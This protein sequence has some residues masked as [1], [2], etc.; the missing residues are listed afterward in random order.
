[1]KSK[2]HTISQGTKSTDN[3][4]WF[5]FFTSNRPISKKHLVNLRKQF[6]KYGNIT[7]ISPITVNSN[8]FIFD[9]QH[10][11]IL[12]EEFGF[13]VH[14]NEA[15][16]DKGAT[17]DMNSNQKPWSPIN[18]VEWFAAYKPEYE[19]L[20]RF[21]ADNKTSFSI[22][23]DVL[24]PNQSNTAVARRLKEGTLEVKEYLTEGQKRMDIIHDIAEILGQELTDAYTRSIMRCLYNDNFSVQR[25]IDKCK[26]VMKSPVKIANPRFTNG[27]DAMHNIES[28]YNYK[29][30]SENTVLLFR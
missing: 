16:L 27:L 3:Y 14:Y 7:E 18:F 28:I 13:P 2:E 1:M 20:R 24:Y 17:P 4:E 12:C 15:K 21:I 9:G 30:T 10:R 22:A 6:Q 29:T 19:L 11:R 26:I 23:A 25:F 5:K 8:G